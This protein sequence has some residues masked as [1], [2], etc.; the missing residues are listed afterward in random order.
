[1]LVSDRPAFVARCPPPGDL[2]RDELEPHVMHQAAAGFADGHGIVPQLT[3]KVM[4]N[5]G[6]FSVLGPS[7]MS[8]WVW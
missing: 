8:R 6:T 5:A 7:C 3:A 4:L 2:L 1:M